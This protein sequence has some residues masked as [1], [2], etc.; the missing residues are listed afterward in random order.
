[1][2]TFA[3]TAVALLLLAGCGVRE[4]PEDRLPLPQTPI[5]TA[6]PR[7]AVVDE[8]Y[9]R[10]FE[11]PDLASRVVGYDREG[12]VLVV[13]SQTNYEAEL[14]GLEAHWYFLEGEVATGWVFGG[15]LKL[16]VSRDRA[17]N[18]RTAYER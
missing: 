6:G 13:L 9:V 17:E 5:L 11:E 15:H 7:W 18:A 16:F 3:L 4:E 14:K 12:S 2:G 1:M 8:P 10:L